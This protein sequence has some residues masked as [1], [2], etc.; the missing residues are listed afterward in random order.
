MDRVAGGAVCVLCAHTRASTVPVSDCPAL[1]RDVGGGRAASIS[2]AFRGDEP[3]PL[4]WAGDESGCVEPGSQRRAGRLEARAYLAEDKRQEGRI[5]IV[6]DG[7]GRRAL[8]RLPLEKCV[9]GKPG[10]SQSSLE[11]RGAGGRPGP[12]KADGWPERP[13][14]G[15]A[16]AV[17]KK[18]GKRGELGHLGA[19]GLRDSEPPARFAPGSADHVQ[20]GDR[21]GHGERPG[22]TPQVET[23]GP[24]HGEGTQRGLC[25]P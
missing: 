23:A 10:T 4:R 22:G 3:R 15:G 16:H 17:M 12:G 19:Q 8:H 25:L 14:C 13:A 1:P 21:A 5:N 6:V 20:P 2:A 7:D 11:P 18:D 24:L 9:W